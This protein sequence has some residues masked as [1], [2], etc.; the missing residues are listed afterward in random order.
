MASI[1]R[2]RRVRAGAVL[3]LALLSGTA[4][5]A[6]PSTQ[7]ADAADPG[8]GHVHGLGVDPAD[9][10]IYIAGHYGLFQVRSTD[11]ARR[12]A[13]RVQDH[14]GFIVIGPKTFLAS[15]HP[16]ANDVPSGG[17]PHLGLIRTTDAGLTWSTVSQAGIADFHAIAPAGTTLYA[18]DSQSGQVRRS[19]NEGQGWAPG[20]ALQVIDLAAHEEEPN[21]VH[22]TTSEGV[23]VSKDGGLTFAGLAGSPLLSHL[24]ALGKDDLVGVGADGRVHASAD[25]GATWQ[26]A[27]RLPGQA[28][29]FTA[30]DRQR[31]LA[32]LQDGTVLESTDGGRGFSVVYRP[33]LS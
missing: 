21:R 24:D 7:T 19:G 11:T 8:I 25:G 1:D 22:A 15:G 18:Y 29:A 9:G 2:H 20:A 33:A 6:Q 4:C 26:A 16:A 30:V 32:A 12:V 10:T 13:D 5:A 23:Q 31:L 17:S 28:A 14:M 27:G 3:A